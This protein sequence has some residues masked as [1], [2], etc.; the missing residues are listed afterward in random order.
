MMSYIPLDGGR[1]IWFLPEAI[2]YAQDSGENSI[3]VTL[4]GGY[5]VE[6]QSHGTHANWFIDSVRREIEHRAHQQVSA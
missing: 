6:V 1:A 3:L 5:Q 2:L 4:L